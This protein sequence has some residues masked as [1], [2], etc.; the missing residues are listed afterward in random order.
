MIQQGQPQGLAAQGAQQQ[1]S[2][3]QMLQQIIQLLMQGVTPQQLEA[4]GV[5]V[6]LIKQA[7]AIIQQH[8]AQSQGQAPQNDQNSNEA[9]QQQPRGL[10][11]IQAG[12]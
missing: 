5:P 6:E 7:I 3:E 9:A 4:K 2:Q 8:Q 11:G 1:P 12:Q 10:A